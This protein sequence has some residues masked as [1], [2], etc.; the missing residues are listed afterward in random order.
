MGRPGRP[1]PHTASAPVGD[2]LGASTALA[3]GGPE[4]NYPR[5][6]DNCDQEKYHLQRRPV[7]GMPGAGFCAPQNYDLKDPR[8]KAV[9]AAPC[10]RWRALRS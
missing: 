6:L 2:S 8:I 7:S 9:V 4:I 10:R 3:L 1:E 5:L